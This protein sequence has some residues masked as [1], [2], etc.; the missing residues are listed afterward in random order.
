[1]NRTLRLAYALVRE[2][3]LEDLQALPGQDH[4]TMDSKDRSHINFGLRPQVKEKL[5]K[6]LKQ[7]RGQ[8]AN[9]DVTRKPGLIE[10]AKSWIWKAPAANGQVKVKIFLSSDKVP[11]EYPPGIPGMLT[12]VYSVRTED[13]KPTPWILAHNIAHGLGAL[14]NRALVK[15]LGI[16][17]GSGFPYTPDVK[18]QQTGKLIRGEEIYETYAQWIATNQV[19]LIP[20]NAQAE[21]QL[22]QVFWMVTKDAMD[23]GTVLDPI[24]ELSQFTEATFPAQKFPWAYGGKNPKEDPSLT[25]FFQP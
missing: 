3:A 4:K 23:Q 11:Y 1:M 13:V 6:W 22:A 21:Q 7:E 14:L 25:E 24:N 16:K 12:L 2:A 17:G 10:K 19:K 8:H 18:S 9:P 5:E 20:R 15:H